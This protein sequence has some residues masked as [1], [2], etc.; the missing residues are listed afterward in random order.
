MLVAANR[1]D[2]AGA[3]MDE[4]LANLGGSVIKPD[5]GVDFPF[6]L[7]ALGYAPDTLDGAAIPPSRWLD[8]ARAFV[9]GDL[10]R[11]A[12]L[13]AEIGSRPDEAYA[14]LAAG[15]QLLATGQTTEGQKLQAAAVDFFRQVGASVAVTR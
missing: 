4:L 3:L 14:R 11:A 12:E 9:A 2:E 13:Y 7:T 5:L 10:N 8:A 6:V 1:V 15:R